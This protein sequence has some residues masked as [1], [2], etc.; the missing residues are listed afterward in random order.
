MDTINFLIDSWNLNTGIS[1]FKHWTRSLPTGYA[2]HSCWEHLQD[3][4]VQG[5]GDSAWGGSEGKEGEGFCTW[6][7]GKRINVDFYGRRGSEPRI[8]GQDKRTC[9]LIRVTGCGWWHKETDFWRG[10]LKEL[11]LARVGE[12]PFVVIPS[13]ILSLNNIFVSPAIQIEDQG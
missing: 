9:A 13:M 1:G 8:G 2:I 7:F 3:C 4:I 5:E 6:N 10:R 11:W 12:V